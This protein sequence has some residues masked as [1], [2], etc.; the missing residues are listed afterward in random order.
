M[1]RPAAG[2]AVVGI[3]K[4]RLSSLL[5]DIVRAQTPDTIES[6]KATVMTKSGA[7]EVSVE[8]LKEQVEAAVVAQKL[9]REK[10]DRKEGNRDETI[11]KLREGKANDGSKGGGKGFQ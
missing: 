3:M 8:N 2:T 5:A 6:S 11:T 9:R 7:Q 4:R 10:Q 1:K